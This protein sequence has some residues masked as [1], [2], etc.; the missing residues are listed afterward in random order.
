MSEFSYGDVDVML[1][2][3]EQARDALDQ[4]VDPAAMTT[5]RWQLDQQITHYQMNGMNEYMI[6]CVAMYELITA[7]LTPIVAL[8]TFAEVI[9]ITRKEPQ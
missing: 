3:I 8:V 5:I 9:G 4:I 6:G 2:S 1:H 7:G